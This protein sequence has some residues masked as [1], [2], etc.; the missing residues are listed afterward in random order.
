M[1]TI[2][3]GVF[4]TDLANVQKGE[5]NLSL[6]I[7]NGK[8]MV[9]LKYDGKQADASLTVSLDSDQYLD[10]LAEAIPGTIDDT[11]IALLKVAMK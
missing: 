11:V 10:M 5:G 2:K 4:M 9:E 8:V 7:E 6:K 3:K 1:G